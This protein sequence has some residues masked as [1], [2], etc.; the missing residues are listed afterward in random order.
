MRSL[1]ASLRNLTL[2]N[3]AT[4]G[5]RIVLDSDKGIIAVYDTRGDLVAQIGFT[6]LPT[7]EDPTTGIQTYGI[8]MLDVARS[9]AALITADSIEWLTYGTDGSSY[10]NGPSVAG[11][12]YN[13]FQN[14]ESKLRLFSGTAVTPVS[15]SMSTM[16]EVLSPSPDGVMPSRV[17]AYG[18]GYGYLPV[19]M[20]VN[21]TVVA[22]DPTVSA[23]TYPVAE[24]WSPLS[25]FNGWTAGTPAPMKRLMPDGT[26]LLKGTANAGNT[27]QG[28]QI[29]SL[30]NPAYY[31][32]GNCQF[33]PKLAAAAGGYG[34]VINT[35]GNA[36]IYDL[37]TATHVTFDGVRFPTASLK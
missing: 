6:A 9:L 35:A 8:T 27:A 2:P 19:T 13:T 26:V 34:L 3:G 37:G 7:V 15:T 33:I 23:N 32:D 10:T 28:T 31:P 11:Q 36:V 16:M 25:L 24:T 18:Q 17:V 5:Q 4:S 12:P 14:F 1:I 29:F 20:L 22:N 21:G 30:T